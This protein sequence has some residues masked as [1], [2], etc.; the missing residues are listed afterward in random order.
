MLITS[1]SQYLIVLGGIKMDYQVKCSHRLY[2]DIIAPPSK[3]YTHRAFVIASLADGE[4]EINN[5]LNSGDTLST[6]NACRAFGVEIELGKFAT[7]KGSHG[8]LKTP[9]NPIDCQNS[10]TTLR[11]ISSM[12][13]LD[14]KV[15]LLGDSSLEK[16]PMGPLLSGLNQLGVTAYSLKDD[17]TLPL[18]VTGGNFTGGRVKIPG[19]FSSQFI[20][21]LLIVS[22]YA[23]EDVEIV[24]TTPPKSRPYIDITLDVMKK[25]G[26]QVNH[27]DY[28]NFMIKSGGRYKGCR[29]DIEGDYTNASYF[30]AL[31]A[32]TDANINILGLKK[33]SKQGDILILQLLEEMGAEVKISKNWV[34]V[35]RKELK[36]IEV[37]LSNSP[38]LVPTVVAIACK[39]HGTTL[40]KNIEHARYKES[41]RITTC[42]QEF[43]KFGVD[44]KEL[45]DGLIIKGSPNLKGALVD[46]HG[47]HRLGMALSILGM[48][49]KGK[50]VIKGAEC[51]G[52]SYPGFFN[53]LE[54]IRR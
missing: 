16:R 12:A 44:I 32:L 53:D 38:D 23:E 30:F 35:R 1:M 47:D 25:F 6:I 51:V 33:N 45:S 19:H 13:S 52:I 39:S 21:S 36:G 50:T 49:S 20:S 28:N 27:T 34:Q 40:I 26:V 42:A 9:K 7:V 5:Y 4:S 43:R 54:H 3:S 48:A 24:L 11:L 22:P 31:S 17:I 8:I 15:T 14:K 18:V 10:G 29:Y 37:D 2:G 46:T 41:D